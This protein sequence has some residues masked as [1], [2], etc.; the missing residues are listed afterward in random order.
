MQCKLCNEQINNGPLIHY[1][2]S[3]DKLCYKCRN[4]WDFKYKAFKINNIKAE[5]FYLYHSGFKDSII[6]YKECYDEYLSDIFLYKLK[7]YIN[8]K[9]YGF[10][11]VLTPSSNSAYTKRGFNHLKQIFKH[12]NL[13]IVDILE[14]TDDLTHK[15][16]TLKERFHTNNIKLKDNIIIPNKILLVD[17]VYISGNTINNCINALNNS[18]TTIK[19]LTLSH[20]IDNN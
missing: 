14:K 19:V 13:N 7:H 1:L 18:N 16:L 6:Q 9:Y 17:D 11:I 4:T 20:N 5:S 12:T 3:E 2:F 10:T 15:H 8:I